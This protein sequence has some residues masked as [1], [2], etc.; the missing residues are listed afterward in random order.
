MRGT[1]RIALLAAVAALITPVATAQYA[2]NRQDPGTR[3][4]VPVP[5]PPYYGDFDASIWVGKSIYNVGDN[6]RINF[7]VSEDAHVFIFSRDPSGEEIQVFPNF[8]QRTNFVRGGQTR[9]LPDGNYRLEVTGPAGYNTLTLIAVRTDY[10]FLNQWRGFSASTPY[11]SARGG[12]DAIKRQVEREGGSVSV[13]G[14]RPV[15]GP[16]GGRYAE[17]TA[18]FTV[19]GGGSP[20]PA[21]RG[22]LYV[23]SDR[24]R[25][26]VYLDGRSVGTTPLN[27]RDLR[28][29][30]YR[31][32]V[33]LDGYWTMERSV[34]IRQ[35]R[36]TAIDADMRRLD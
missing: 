1:L 35:G 4:V 23:K 15:P 31:M 11:P 26:R 8:Y 12:V 13:R 16:G 32:R 5:N 36:I 24:P 17:A 9:S 3:A 28:P 22:T 33:E 34:T 18:V 10:P 25:V 2:S 14:V 27:L 30:T 21:G 20:I 19:R 7:S 29:G 6:I